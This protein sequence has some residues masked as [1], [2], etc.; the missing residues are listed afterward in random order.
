MRTTGASVPSQIEK[1]Q[2]IL[3]SKIRSFIIK[4]LFKRDHM[5]RSAM[6][7]VC[8]DLGSSVV[9]GVAVCSLI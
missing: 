7:M 8:A 6:V 4:V 5:F 3:L 9:G 2:S 1:R